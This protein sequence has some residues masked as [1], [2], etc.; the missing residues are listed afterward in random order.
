[1]TSRID[2]YRFSA[3]AP[4]AVSLAYLPVASLSTP[5]PLPLPPSLRPRQQ[6]GE[7]VRNKHSNV[8]INNST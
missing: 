1:M 6:Q 8:I 7:E 5:P 4:A 3:I 2:G